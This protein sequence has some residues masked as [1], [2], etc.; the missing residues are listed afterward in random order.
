MPEFVAQFPPFRFALVIHKSAIWLCIAAF[1]T[2][3]AKAQAAEAE[4]NAQRMIAPAQLAI[5][6]GLAYLAAR[7]TDDGAFSTSGQGRNSAVCALGGMAFL[8]A[9]STPQPGTLRKASCQSP[10]IS[11]WITLLPVDSFTSPRR[12]CMGPC[13]ATALPPCF[14]LKFTAWTTGPIYARSSRGPSN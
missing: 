11:Y 10:R 1:M 9:G 12:A 2:N 4:P 14:W 3:A 8:S 5:D 6:T 7:Q 13:T